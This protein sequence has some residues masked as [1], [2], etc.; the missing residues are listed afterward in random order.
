MKK[1]VALFLFVA[2]AFCFSACGDDGMSHDEYEQFSKMEDELEQY[3]ALD[4]CNILTEDDQEDF[5][6][7]VAEQ[8]GEDV[9]EEVIDMFYD[10]THSLGSHID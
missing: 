5:Y 3:R 1:I 9:A 7:S 4:D 6:G 2:M 10:N 8:Y